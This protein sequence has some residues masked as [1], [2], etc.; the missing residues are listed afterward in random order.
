MNKEVLISE[1]T[2]KAI[3]SS[4]AGGQH[5]NKVSSKVVLSFDLANSEGLSAREKRLL[6]KSI[7]ARLTKGNVLILSCDESKSQPQNK[8]RVIDRFL[9][10]ITKGLFVPKRRI[11]TKPTKGS[12]KRTKESKQKRSDVKKLRKTPKL[13]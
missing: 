12:V 4:G 13:D 5:V 2:Y 11:A 3:R 10:I 6:N 9:D 8:K 7:G 1:L